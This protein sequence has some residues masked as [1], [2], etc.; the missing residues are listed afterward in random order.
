MFATAAQ[1]KELRGLTSAPL[2]DC[3][4][5]LSAEGVNGDMQAAVDWLRKN[6]VKT[7]AKKASRAASEGC[8][9]VAVDAT[10]RS[11]ALVEVCLR[12]MHQLWWTPDPVMHSH[13]Y[14]PPGWPAARTHSSGEQ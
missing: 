1:V 5:A 7:A 10:G 2:S 9:G 3:K 12:C 14:H 13:T 4:K 8:V 6:G 11:A